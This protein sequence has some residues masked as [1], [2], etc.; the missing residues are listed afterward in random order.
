MRILV[1]FLLLGLSC[2]AQEN[3][4]AGAQDIGA[5]TG[6]VVDASGA[7]IKDASVSCEPTQGSVQGI[8]KTANTDENGAFMLTQ[9]PK[10]ENMVV[11]SKPS[12]FYADARFAFF[13]SGIEE[14]PT[15]NIS[16]AK[17]IS[18]VLI[19][20]SHKGASITGAI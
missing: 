1:A 7:P 2:A 11:A 13:A 15:V 20:L 12:D 9:V 17:T 5:V 3:S 14:F 8:L 19:R 6:Q 16:D 4:D 10:G 18:G